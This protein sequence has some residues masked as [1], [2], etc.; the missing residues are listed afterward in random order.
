MHKILRNF[1]YHCEIL[2]IVLLFTFFTIFMSNIFKFS[3][4]IPI[5][6][7]AE[8]LKAVTLRRYFHLFN[9]MYRND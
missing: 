8:A 5:T 4:L 7:N 2:I 1:Q 3:C 9:S 6:S